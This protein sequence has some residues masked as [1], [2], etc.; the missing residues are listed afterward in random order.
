MTSLNEVTTILLPSVISEVAHNRLVIRKQES[1]ESIKK[2]ADILRQV[3]NKPT[4][5]DIPLE[6][7]K[8]TTK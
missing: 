8:T 3:Q 7:T 5:I 4:E 6:E 2:V 1:I